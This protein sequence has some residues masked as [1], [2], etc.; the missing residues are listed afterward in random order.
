[1]LSV[2]RFISACAGV[3]AA[4]SG[5]QKPREIEIKYCDKMT[6]LRDRDSTD[7]QR[8]IQE[9]DAEML[10]IG[11]SSRNCS[12]GS[13]LTDRAVNEPATNAISFWDNIHRAAQPDISPEKLSHILHSTGHSV[14]E[15]HRTSS[16]QSA[17]A[18]AEMD[19]ILQIQQVNRAFQ[20]TKTVS[21]PPAGAPVHEV[22][23]VTSLLG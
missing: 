19:R 17:N 8:M 5:T 14:N 22:H 18:V 15:R 20:R 4:Q 21:C 10:K 23:D 6:R 2:A 13:L 1:L 16:L 7:F 11:T 9:Q 12:G 3:E